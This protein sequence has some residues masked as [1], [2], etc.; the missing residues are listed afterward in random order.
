MLKREP[1]N[2]N[3][4]RSITLITLALIDLLDRQSFDS[5]NITDI[6]RAAGLVR[7]TFYAHFASKEAVLSHHMFRLV[8]E[9]M[10]EIPY[11]AD[12]HDVYVV[13]LFF[14]TW[15]SNRSFLNLL[16]KHR[17]LF[18]LD[19]AEAHATKLGLDE[20]AFETCVVSQEAEPYA[21]TVYV[22]ILVS[23]A[24]RWIST[25]MKESPSKLVE[26]YR[27]LLPHSV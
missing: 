14:E 4:R 1:A 5:I 3:S 24:K 10:A 12:R 21:R 13:S 25:G 19:D 22:G 7:N 20:R 15:S 26:I 2:N 8:A 6:T 18:L 9:K 16:D 23:I 27:E 11:P 17:L